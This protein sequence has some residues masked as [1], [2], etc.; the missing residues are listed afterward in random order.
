MY[1]NVSLKILRYSWLNL[2]DQAE[3]I[4]QSWTN[5]YLGG[6]LVL[7]IFGKKECVARTCDLIAISNPR[8]CIITDLYGESGFFHL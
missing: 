7:T 5:C 2:L 6:S 4:C 8:Q 1:P 3:E